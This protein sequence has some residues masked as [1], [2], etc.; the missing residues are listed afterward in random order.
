MSTETPENN[1]DMPEDFD[2]NPEAEARAAE[3]AAMDEQSQTHAE[4][5][6]HAGYDASADAL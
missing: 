6:I 5:D 4:D 1:N 2:A 3:Q